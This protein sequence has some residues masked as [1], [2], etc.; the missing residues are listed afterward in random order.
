MFEIIP[1]ILEK[2]WEA[3]A[4]KIEIVKPFAKAIH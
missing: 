3:I 2:D 1:G 4:K